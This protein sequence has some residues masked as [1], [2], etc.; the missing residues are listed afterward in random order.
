MK[1]TFTINISGALFH[2][3]EDAYEKLQGYLL[4]L[5]EHFGNDAE[6][7]EI[8]ADIE[9]RISELFTEKAKGENRVISAKWV[10]EVISTMGTPEDFLEQEH[11]GEPLLAVKGRKRLYRATD[12]RVIG[13][14]CSGLSAYFKVDPLVMRILFV[15]LFFANGIG[16]LAYLILWIAV[17]GAVTTAQKLEMR[18]EEVTIS[19]IEKRV[20]DENPEMKAGQAV[21]VTGPSPAENRPGRQD[22]AGSRAAGSILKIG[23]TVIGILLIVAGFM[24]LLG[25]I[26]TLVVGQTFLS[27]WPLTW[28]NDF[29]ASGLLNQFVSSG[30]VTWGL[31][32]VALLT[33]IPLLAMLYVGTKLIFNYKSN[34]IAIGLAM[35]GIWLLALVG[36]VAVVANEASRFKN[37]SSLSGTETLYPAPGKTL[38][39]VVAADKFEDFSNLHWDID[40]FRA[41]RVDNKSVLL[42]EPRFDIEKSPTTDVVLVVKKYARGKTQADANENIRKIIYNYQKTD[43]SITFDPWY[44]LGENG[45]WYGQRVDITLKIPEGTSVFLSEGMEEIIYDIENVS[46]T[47]DGD[48]VGK[49]WIMLPE[50]LTMKDSLD[51]KA[52][53]I[54]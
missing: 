48:M 39:L 28:N 35:V 31:F 41:V 7:R 16:L 47:W 5:K 32:L 9:N 18:G 14:V 43:S 30:G 54:K 24:G 17:P 44:M 38:N 45:K 4:K 2:I 40:R 42:G 19:N 10:D 20:R 37:T 15:V 34:N 23:V 36:L 27:E 3:E 33:G 6:G 53:S 12:N 21:G 11:T 51:V 49:T 8:V 13:G 1:K 26:S 46:H 22:D 25:L 29:Q 52:D 50:G